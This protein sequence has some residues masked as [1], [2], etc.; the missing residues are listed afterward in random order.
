[1]EAA[2]LRKLNAL[3]EENVRLKLMNADL[4][5]EIT[6]HRLGETGRSVQCRELCFIQA[7]G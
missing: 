7:I 3:T 4:T 2:D 1:M 6:T 5:L